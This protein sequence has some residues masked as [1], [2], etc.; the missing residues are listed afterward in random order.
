M[1]H[2]ISF[3][4]AKLNNFQ[5]LSWKTAFVFVLCMSACCWLPLMNSSIRIHLKPSAFNELSTTLEFRG[6]F[7]YNMPVGFYMFTQLAFEYYNDFDR[8][9]YG[10][11][12]RRNGS[13][14]L[15]NKIGAIN[16]G[17]YSILFLSDGS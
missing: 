6:L 3:K 4:S 9:I 11:I 8:V 10:E 16:H 2:R 7:W 13:G 15:L 14:A 1:V 12:G 17:Y 5:A